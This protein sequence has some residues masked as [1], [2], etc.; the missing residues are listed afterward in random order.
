MNKNN[1]KSD[2]RAYQ[3]DEIMQRVLNGLNQEVL[4]EE[5]WKHAKSF[6]E[7]REELLALKPDFVAEARE[8]WIKIGEARGIELGKAEAAAVEREKMLEI[9]RTLKKSGV[10]IDLIEKTTKLKREEIEKL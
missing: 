2:F 5:E 3:N 8:E 9:A 4:D 6:E 10:S 7:M 1:T